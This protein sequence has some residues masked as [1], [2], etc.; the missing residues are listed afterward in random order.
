MKIVI[1]EKGHIKQDY[2]RGSD[3]YKRTPTKRRESYLDFDYEGII[4][5]SDKL[6][7]LEF[8]KTCIFS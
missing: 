4:E 1:G 6:N 5:K 8:P 7:A 2:Y 3:T